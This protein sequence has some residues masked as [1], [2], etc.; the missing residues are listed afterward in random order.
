MNRSPSV[1][2]FNI[3]DPEKQTA[4]RLLSLRLGI[5]CLEVPPEGQGLTLE[6]LLDG[7]VGGAP[8]AET[9]FTEEMMLL[10]SL[11]SDAFNTLLDTLRREGR[12]VRLKAVVTEHNRNWTASRLHRELSAEAEAMERQK[13]SLHTG[14]G[15]KRK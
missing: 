6:A 7:A 1:L 11:P 3:H 14:A 9:P 8:A 5:R 10:S 15:K 2:V 13:K 12:S 4:I